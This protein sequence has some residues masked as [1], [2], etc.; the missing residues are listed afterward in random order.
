MRLGKTQASLAFL[1]A[2]TIF[3]YLYFDLPF[4]IQLM[5]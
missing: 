4:V 2:F 1:P 5:N 3:A